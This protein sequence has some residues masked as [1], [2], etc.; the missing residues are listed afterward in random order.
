M[1][2]VNNTAQNPITPTDN[3]AMAPM[4]DALATTDPTAKTEPTVQGLDARHIFRQ[5]VV[6]NL[7]FHDYKQTGDPDIQ[8]QLQIHEVNLIEDLELSD[9]NSK[10]IRKLE[11]KSSAVDELVEKVLKL[12]KKLDQVITKFAPEWPLDQINPVDLAILRLGLVEG[13]VD[14]TI[15]ARV[16]I[17]ECIELAREFG[18][19]SNAKFISGVLG[20]IYNK[21]GEKKL[22]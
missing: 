8:N 2:E 1:E 17:N 7:Y 4:P 12:K 11:K 14:Q 13:F 15:P 18:G 10:V 5:L 20:N 16:A 3:N 22:F 19:E 6:Q 21:F 9:R